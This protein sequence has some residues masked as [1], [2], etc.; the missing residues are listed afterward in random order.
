MN[1]DQR[2]IKAQ[3]ELI[4]RLNDEVRKLRSDVLAERDR[5]HS[6]EAPARAWRLMTDQVKKNTYL[7]GEFDRFLLALKLAADEVYLDQSG[8]YDQKPTVPPQSEISK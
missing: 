6:D 8:A 5:R 7:Q 2:L 1:S 3:G 4:S